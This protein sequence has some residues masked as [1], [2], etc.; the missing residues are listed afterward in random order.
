VCMCGGLERNREGNGER[1]GEAEREI[2][3][4]RG[5]SAPLRDSTRHVQLNHN[6][7]ASTVITTPTPT[8][9]AAAAAAVA[10]AAIEQRHNSGR[11][12]YVK[13]SRGAVG[14]APAL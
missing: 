3:T 4:G 7:S 12:M 6:I 8:I 9:A 5:E 1:E 13:R 2:E 11:Y 10:A 14:K